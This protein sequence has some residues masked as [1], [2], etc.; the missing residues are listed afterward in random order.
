MPQ[1][2]EFCCF[3]SI[4]RGSR[5]QESKLRAPDPAAA[6]RTRRGGGCW[7]DSGVIEVG[8]SCKGC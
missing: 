8:T 1:A 6:G 5:R 2:H 4:R 3:W 7:V